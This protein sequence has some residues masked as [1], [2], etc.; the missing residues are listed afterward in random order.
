M[1][2]NLIIEF[3]PRSLLSL[4][5]ILILMGGVWYVDRTWDEKA[6]AAYERTNGN[7]SD[8][9]LD[10][11]FPFPIAFIL[12][13]IIFAAAY[14]FPLNGG[15]TLD[16][17]PLNI[18]AI[19]FSL[20]LA[21]V[22]SVPMGD[23]VRHRKAGK[24]MKLSM[25]FVLSWLGLT[26]TSG[27]S[28][29]TGASAFIFGG[30]GAI[31]II[32]SMKLL[33]KYRKM[34][35]SWEQDGKPNPN[36]IVYNM[37][38]PLFVLGW[39]FFWISMSGTTG[40]SGDLEIYFNLRT[41]LAFFAGCG[42]VPIVMMLD[43]A[44]DEGGKYIGLGTSGAHFGRLFESIVPF[45]TM[46]ILFGVA[47]FIAIDNTFTNPDTRHWLLLV[48]C[49]LQALTAG[50]LIQTALYKGNMANKR[51]FSMIFVLLFLALAINI[52]W[53]GGLARYFALAGAAFVIAGQMNVF[54]D[55]KRG[56]YW[57]INKKPNPNPIV[58]SIGEPLFMTGWILLSLAMSQPIL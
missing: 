55:R 24:K 11:A 23:A 30:L 33:W 44:H 35:D 22:A 52:G 3:G 51:K 21:V 9:D 53:D 25:M 20:L 58:Y 28:V 42:M 38:G 14:L 8:K 6:S 39:F 40:A 16:F 56:D 32:A 12:G 29:G 18:A 37:G 46:W 34:G 36:P 43:Y 41:T 48:T 27:L 54:K 1:N 7:P 45:L 47:S 26:I 13:W 15:T 2:P 10:T 19:V 4:A 31:F 50:G 49:I 5:G 57:M 17:N